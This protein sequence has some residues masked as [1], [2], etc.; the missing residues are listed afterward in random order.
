MIGTECFHALWGLMKRTFLRKQ[1][2]WSGN[3]PT[4]EDIRNV[5]KDQPD[6]TPGSKSA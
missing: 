4:L 2:A 5:L 6:T 1:K 3:E